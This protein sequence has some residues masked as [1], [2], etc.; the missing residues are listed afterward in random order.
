[1]KLIT[2][3][4]IILFP[5]Y[6]LP[7]P[8]K[9]LLAYSLAVFWFYVLRLRVSYMKERVQKCFPEKTSREVSWIVFGSLYNLCMVLMDY[10]YFPFS[11]KVLKKRTELINLERLEKAIQSDRPVFL[12]VA[13][14]GNGEI[15]VFRTCLE[16]FK[17]NLIAKRVKN[18]FID[19]MLFE[20]RELSGLK[21]IPPKHG[22]EG[23]LNAAQNKEPV[24]FVH[25]QFRHPPRGVLTTF[26]GEETY[27]NSALAFFALKE[28]A[29]VLPAISYRKNNQ[30]IA[31]FEEVIPLDRPYETEHENVVHMTQI[32]NDHVES[33]VRERPES[34][35]WVHKRWKKVGALS[36]K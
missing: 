22:A 15:S 34:W 33:W 1:M 7:R 25:D 4:K 26:F 36:D 18:S 27:T 13:H 21:H 35:M 8:F 20:V 19:S 23:I 28:N 30:I 11:K 5:I 32:F 10:S 31:E 16:G 24:L 2:K 29:I 6:I 17:L 9:K 14:L 12:L 3:A